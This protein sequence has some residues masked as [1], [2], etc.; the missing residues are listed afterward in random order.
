M[1]R[2]GEE[3]ES[4]QRAARRLI[5]VR[6]AVV[7]LALVV[8][9]LTS[10]S[11][12]T[13]ARSAV[14]AGAAAFAYD[15]ADCRQPSGIAFL[16][17]PGRLRRVLLPDGGV[18]ARVAA[19][20][21]R[22]AAAWSTRGLVSSAPIVGNA[23]GAATLH[24]ALSRNGSSDFAVDRASNRLVVWGASDGL[25]FQ[26]V[27]N[28]GT[29]SPPLL[30][31]K[32][33]VADDFFFPQI[34]AVE[35]DG[36]AWIAWAPPA[37]SAALVVQRVPPDGVPGPPVRLFDANFFLE[38]ADV[39][40]ATRDGAGGIFALVHWDDQDPCGGLTPEHRPR[41]PYSGPRHTFRHRHAPGRDPHDPGSDQW[42]ARARE[43][44]RPDRLPSPRERTPWDLP[45]RV[46][47]RREPLAAAPPDDLQGRVMDA[48]VQ[49][50]T[51]RTL[52]LLRTSG[53]TDKLFS[54]AFHSAARPAACS[55][56]QRAGCAPREK[57][58]QSP[59]L[60]SSLTHA[61]GPF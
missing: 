60:T 26:R 42:S 48:A 28:T 16:S 61:D 43:R 9:F 11:E 4:N 27:T 23:F 34:L 46:N 15:V 8:L 19:S 29:P 3:L 13:A 20:G 37:T 52:T 30:L 25:R 38:T 2:P 36:S 55:A 24:G 10:T 57:A 31:Q 59:G 32:G 33:R 17:G 47:S 50:G 18:A 21:G 54:F 56:S 39:L 44:G 22:F 5:G 51:N 45:S 40:G 41:G 58:E 1:H 14:G 53:T 6:V 49:P 12:A 35:A 7:W